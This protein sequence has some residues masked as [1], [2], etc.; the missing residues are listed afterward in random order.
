MQDKNTLIL[1][2]VGG[3]ESIK[4]TAMAK[5]G[6]VSYPI[7]YD[8]KFLQGFENRQCFTPVSGQCKETTTHY[9][10]MQLFRVSAQFR[11]FFLGYHCG[12]HVPWRFRCRAPH[13]RC[14]FEFFFV[15]RAVACLIM[16]ACHWRTVL[17]QLYNIFLV[18]HEIVAI[19]VLHLQSIQ[20]TTT[21]VCNT[22]H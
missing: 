6:F 15:Q 3:L 11:V 22:V 18:L 19:F 8:W 16:Y 2:H 10:G 20:F 17:L 1:G 13:L 14:A 5:M 4:T 21:T 12:Y 9:A 7:M